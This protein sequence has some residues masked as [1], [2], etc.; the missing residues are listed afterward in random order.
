MN[1]LFYEQLTP[2]RPRLPKIL[3]I[4][5]IALAAAIGVFLT[6]GV[7]LFGIIFAMGLIWL[8]HRFVRPYTSVEYEY[9]LTNANLTV[10]AIYGKEKRA[11]LTNI[12][13]REAGSVNKGRPGSVQGYEKVFDCVSPEADPS[14]VCNVVYNE[15]GKRYLLL[16]TPDEQMM[17]LLRR[18]VPVR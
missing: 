8:L 18:V 2:G 5:L 12:N 14:T 11:S 1:D 10:D 7:S 15:G 9:C 6:L 3:Y 17:S 16:F 13:L 4:L